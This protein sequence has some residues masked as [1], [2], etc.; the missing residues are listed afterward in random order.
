[1]GDRGSWSTLYDLYAPVVHAA[2][3]VSVGSPD[4]DDLTQEVFI[5]AMRKINS[6]RDDAA[7]GAWLLSI[8]RRRAGTL[9]RVRSLF[10]R[11]L[12]RLA[13]SRPDRASDHANAPAIRE[14][15]ITPLQLLDAIRSL[16]GAYHETLALRL[17]EQLQGPEIARRLGLTHASVRVNLSRGMKLLREKLAPDR[18]EH[19]P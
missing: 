19:S 4:A 11:T 16:P 5:A 17:I 7:F 13:G 2:L 1:R 12:P 6:L 10:R 3:L 14:F 9:F 15:A 8:A 18:P